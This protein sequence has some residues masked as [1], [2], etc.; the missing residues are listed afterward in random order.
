MFMQG[1]SA[2]TGRAGDLRKAP[3][4]EPIAPQRARLGGLGFGNYTRQLKAIIP[5]AGPVP[6]VNGFEYYRATS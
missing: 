5:P 4:Q 1:Q 2:T 6:V 3:N